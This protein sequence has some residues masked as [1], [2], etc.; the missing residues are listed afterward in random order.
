M[1][2]F[3][4]KLLNTKNFTYKELAGGLANI[5][6][7]VCSENNNYIL[8]KFGNITIENRGTE[9]EIINLLTKFDISRKIVNKFDGGLLET[10]IEGNTLNIE[11]INNNIIL[12]KICHNM[13]IMHNINKKIGNNIFDKINAITHEI[14][15]KEYYNQELFDYINNINTQKYN[16]LP[17]GLC[18]NDLLF[19]NIIFNSENHKLSFIDLEYA[20]NNYIH[21]DIANF[22]CE[23]CGMNCDISLFPNQKF[24]YKFYNYYEMVIFAPPG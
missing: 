10:Y 23:I 2:L 21:F 17:K 16:D 3:I 8:R 20:G 11:N 14:K 12:E 22:F 15:K 5:T 9:I 18:H 19:E 4:E 1:K 7:K 24:R 13:K 6:Y